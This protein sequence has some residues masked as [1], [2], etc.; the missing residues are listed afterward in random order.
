MELPKTAPD[1]VNTVVVLELSSPEKFD[2]VRY[3]APN[4]PLTR[5]LAF[6]AT[7]MGKGFGFGD[8]KTVV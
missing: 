8:G 1:T 4:I 2:S 7:L 6:D 5:M 3:L